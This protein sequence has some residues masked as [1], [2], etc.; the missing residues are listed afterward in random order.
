MCRKLWSRLA[1]VFTPLERSVR[2]K[3][4]RSSTSRHSRFTPAGWLEYMIR[5]LFPWNVA[6]SRACRK[7]SDEPVT[8]ALRLLDSV[9][10]QHNSRRI[11]V[12][13]SA[14][15][16]RHIAFL[17]IGPTTFA[18]CRGNNRAKNLVLALKMPVSKYSDF[19][20][21]VCHKG[22]VFGQVSD[23]PV[24][25]TFSNRRTTLVAIEQCHASARLANRVFRSR[26][27]T[28]CGWCLHLSAPL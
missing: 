5:T 6:R 18:Q 20:G 9:K 8:L 24:F 26:V 21:Q 2:G 7:A 16:V 12:T 13:F 17:E 10:S 3:Q 4:G 25:H 27:R 22:I 19:M 14:A 11:L 23:Y 1:V 15:C 28:V